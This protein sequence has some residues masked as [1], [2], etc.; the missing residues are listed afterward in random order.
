MYCLCEGRT[1]LCMRLIFRKL[2]R[3]L[4]MFLTGFTSLSV[5]FFF[6]YRS[7]CSSLYMVLDSISSNTDEVLSINPSDNVFVFQDLNVHH[8][9]W[10]SYSGG[11]DRF[12]ELC[13]NFT[14]PYS[15][16]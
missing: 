10:L 16:D 2:C 7:P 3:L 11:T 12:G 15:Y 8:K 9:N 4:F 13:Y 5:Y 1:S 6:P 14:Q